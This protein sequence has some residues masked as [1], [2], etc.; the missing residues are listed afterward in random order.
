MAKIKITEKQAALLKKLNPISEA[1]ETG[2]KSVGVSIGEKVIRVVISGEDLITFKDRILQLITRLDPEARV[3]YFEATGKIVGTIKAIRLDAIKRDIKSLNPNILVQDKPIIK[4]LKEIKKKVKITKEQYI[5]LFADKIN[6]SGTVKGGLDRVDKTFKKAF[7]DKT[8]KNLDEENFNIKKPNSSI[9][10]LNKSVGHRESAINENTDTFKREV[11]ELIKF[12]YGK[13]NY[14]SP[15]WEENG[16]GYN[17]IINVL[18]K[19]KIIIRNDNSYELSKSLGTPQAAIQAVET[20]LQP[21]I[22]QEEVAEV[23]EIQEPQEPKY[24]TPVTPKIKEFKTVAMNPEIAILK[25]AK[26]EFY[27]FNYLD[28]DKKAFS[29][30]AEIE[31]TYVGKDDEG[32][33]DFDYS[34]NWDIEPYVIDNYINDNVK[35]ISRGEGIDAFESGISLVKIDKPLKDEIERLYDKD[36]SIVGSLSSIEE[37]IKTPEEVKPALSAALAPPANTQKKTPDAIKAALAKKREE[38]LNRRKQTGELEEMT[39]AASSGA[40]TGPMSS[41]VIKR[42]IATEEEVIDETTTAASS[43]QYDANAFPNIGR[44]GEFKNEGKT[45]AQIKTQYPK[46]GF[47]KMGKC[48][49]L[50]NGKGAENGG[51][52]QGAIDN[53]VTVK[54]S[55]KSVISP[56]LDENAIIEQIA[57]ETG[58]TIDEVKNIIKTKIKKTN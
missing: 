18:F 33:P 21:M 35:G 20:T 55:K 19:N 31:K 23:E 47:V 41:P 42:E 51:C 40:F 38:E 7:S 3:G 46:G 37:E 53:V 58:K 12:L 34:D 25:N 30:Y 2:V 50:D 45:P 15:F 16:I 5:R 22:K 48:T 17:T 57:K 43:G 13:A 32:N 52:S 28:L 24:T 29:D 14:I 8:V 36:K 27:V 54:G 56:S 4:S 39:G 1:E 6:E 44:N 10:K 11:E 9:P 26:G 49:K